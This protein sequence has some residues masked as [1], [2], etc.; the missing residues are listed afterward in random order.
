MTNIKGA[1]LK[2]PRRSI[3]DAAEALQA[4]LAPDQDDPMAGNN[5][6]M[7]P[8]DQASDDQENMGAAAMAGDTGQN[9]QGHRDMSAAWQEHCR[10][11]HYHYAD[12]LAKYAEAITPKKP[13]PQ[14]LV[15]DPASYAAQL[16]SYEDLTAKRD[17]IVQEVI[18]IS[19]QN[20]MAELAARQ[21]WAQGEHQ[22]LMSIFPEW[23]DDNQR[24]AILAAFEETGRH[25][26]Y[27]DHVLAA[28]D[29][30]DIMALKKA[31]EWR[32]KSE[33]WDALQQG[34]T[35]AIKSAK[36]SRKTAVPGTSQPYGAAK[37]RKLNESLGQLR[38]SGDVR[39]AAAAMNALFK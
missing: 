30:N 8:S 2:R 7:P 1:V 22:R 12:Q 3:Q 31:H 10:A 36:I 35:A 5:A 20:E 34:K 32:R 15:S 6:D 24:P 19:R 16:A 17:Q 13:D 33:K 26:G 29:S 4:N 38:K 9:N 39:S 28:A 21:A 27:P 14:L 11:L 37:S 23:A 18:Q 25:L